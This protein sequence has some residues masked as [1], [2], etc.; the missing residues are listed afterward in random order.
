VLGHFCSGIVIVTGME[1]REPIGLTCQSFTSVSL[2]P[3]LVGFL[4]DKGSSSWPK[5]QAAGAFCVNMLG[6]DQEDICRIFATK[7]ADKFATIGWKPGR[8]GAPII[9]DVTAHIECELGDVIETG[10][11]YFVLGKVVDLEVN[12]QGGPLVFYRGG[13]GRYT[14]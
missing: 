14:V 4:P 8:T 9:N 2:D 1:G 5:I 3:P 6:E 11:H 10:D 13:Y 7:S 12:H